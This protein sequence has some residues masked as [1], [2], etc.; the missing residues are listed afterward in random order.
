VRVL[1]DDIDDDASTFLVMELLE[2][3]TL[4]AEWA[5]NGQ[6][7]PL[8]WAA[9]VVDDLLDVLDAIHAAGIVH[10]D[11]KP[12]NV[13]LVRGAPLKVLDLGVARILIESRMTASGQIVGT[14]GFMAPEQARGNVRAITGRADLYSVGA[15]MFTLLTGR[16]VHE[17]RT[18]REAMIFGATRPARSLAEVWPSAPPPL[19]HVVDVALAFEQERRWGNV[20]EMRTALA[21]AMRLASSAGPARSSAPPPQGSSGT[22]LGAGSASQQGTPL[23]LVP[24]RAHKKVGQKGQVHPSRRPGKQMSWPRVGPRARGPSPT[25][26]IRI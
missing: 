7:L 23:P 6:V 20:A 1:D 12:D 24:A 16:P 25:Q 5:A 18:P 13:F 10:R 19:V 22:L 14:P 21:S 8:P 17:A 15:R 26:C 2:G 4:A 9:H 3:R 11:I